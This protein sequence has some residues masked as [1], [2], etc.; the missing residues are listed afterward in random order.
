MAVRLRVA[1]I[2][3]LLLAGVTAVARPAGA[4]YSK[5]QFTGL[6]QC[7]AAMNSGSQAFLKTLAK[8]LGACAQAI[9]LSDLKP[10]TPDIVDSV[11]QKCHQLY[12][13]I[14]NASTAFIDKVAGAC[15]PVRDLVLFDPGDPLG[16]QVLINAAAPYV[17]VVIDSM[18]D[19]AGLI[20]G[21]VAATAEI[22]AVMAVPRG[23][24]LMLQLFGEPDLDGRCFVPSED[25]TGVGG[26]VI[27]GAGLPPLDPP[28]E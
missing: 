2:A 26:G 23:A 8:N 28:G 22:P 16:I 4:Q 13:G 20:C 15:G 27:V 18:T 25:V 1:T 17:P 24:G 14:R 3:L 21:T 9:A 7:Q 12:G 11:T 6:K 19:V 10:L 5:P